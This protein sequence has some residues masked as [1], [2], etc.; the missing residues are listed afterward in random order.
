L[1]SIEERRRVGSRLAGDEKA[2]YEKRPARAR[3]PAEETTARKRP[4]S[5]G[6]D[7]SEAGYLSNDCPH[8]GGGIEFPLNGV[9]QWIDC[10]HCQERIQ[11][12]KPAL[13]A[14]FLGAAWKWR[15][16]GAIVLA[17]AI[18]SGTALFIYFDHRGQA[19]E[20]DRQQAAAERVRLDLASRQNRPE[21]SSAS[22]RAQAE[23]SAKTEA[24]LKS[25]Q[26]G[27]EDLRETNA[28]LTSKLANQ[29][30]ASKTPQRTFIAPQQSSRRIRVYEVISGFGA[31]TRKCRTDIGEIWIPGLPGQVEDY[32]AEVRK[33]KA[34]EAEFRAKVEAYDR[35]A[36]RASA[37]AATGASGDPAYVEAV[38]RQRAE[39]NLML[40]N[41]R[42]A[43]ANLVKMQANLSAWEKVKEERTTILAVSAR[44]G[45]WNY[46]GMASTGPPSQAL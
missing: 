34:E 37:V 13:S 5:I 15:A 17:G 14:R 12:A 32:L 36:R 40:E 10:P 45:V 25:L 38:M 29:E 8:C 26:R 46:V 16:A 24:M 42:D 6:G 30:N 4:E 7:M 28:L 23:Q 22:D 3:N 33:L 39:A 1:R 41:A 18:V 44:P 27:I 2:K 20:R 19:R 21:E 43:S 9:G 11:L 31:L 35:D